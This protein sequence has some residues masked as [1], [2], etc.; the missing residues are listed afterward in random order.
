MKRREFLQGA[1][2]T[3]MGIVA[4]NS[5]RMTQA[6]QTS[7]ASGTPSGV[8]SGGDGTIKVALVGCGSRGTGAASQVLQTKGPIKLWAMADLFAD[9]LEASYKNLTQGMAKSWDRDPTAGLNAKI[10]VPPERRFVGFDAYQKAID[11]GA[12]L[13]LLTTHQHFRPMHYAY[14]VKQG[15]HVFMEKPLGVDVPGIRQILAANEEAKKKNLK[16]GVGLYMRH[17]RAVQETV[18]RVRD[19][20]VGPIVMMS[21]FFNLGGLHNTP[22]RPADMTEMTYQLRNPFH[23]VWLSGD[24]IVDAVVHYFDLCLWL[25]GKPPVTAQGQGGRQFYLPTQQGDVFDHQIVEYTFA[26]GVKMFGQTRAI[27]GCWHR[28]AAEI[29]GPAGCADLWGRIEGANPWRWKGTAANPYQVEHDVLIDAIRQNKPYNDVDHAAEATL[30]GI[31][32][33]MASYS[34]QSITWEQMNRSKVVLAPEKYAFDA[35]PPVVPDATGR[36]PVGMPGITKVI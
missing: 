36:Y 3:S 7:S 10:D 32:G 11:S 14:A 9:R 8:F 5:G 18:A 12:D 33:R 1:V 29:H 2:A 20:A 21:C 17:S 23:F 4:A 28:S 27:S 22:S 34:G 24:D 16:V 19:G 13:V 26:D 30:V 15:K 31:M 6:Q 25:K 35:T